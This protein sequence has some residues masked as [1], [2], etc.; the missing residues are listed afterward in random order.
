MSQGKRSLLPRKNFFV[1]WMLFTFVIALVSLQANAAAAVSPIQSA[2]EYDYPPFSIVTKDGQADGFSVELLREALRA[3]G[4]DVQFKV[5]PWHQLKQELADG[6]IQVLPLV[7]R[8]AERKLVYE[9]TA[10]YMSMHGTLIARKGDPR[11][12]GLD[13][14]RDKALVVLKGDNA[15]EYA[16]E[17][18]LTDKLVETETL[19]IGLRQLA[20]GQH[21]AML[22]QKLVGEN[23]IKT[24]GLSNLKTVGPPIEQFQDFCFAVRL[25]DKEL[26]A[27]LNEGLA[28]IIANDTV[29]RLREKWITPTR[30]EFYARLR[31]QLAIVLG[32]FLLAA[33]P[34]YL[35][36]RSKLAEVNRRAAQLIDSEAKYKRLVENSPDIVYAFSAKKGGIYYSPK[37]TEVLGYSIDHLYA[38]P[39]LWNESIHPDD[40]P[41][42][43]KA[44]TEF[45]KGCPF[46][47][48]Y[49]IKD[50]HGNWHWLHDRSIGYREENGDY[51]LEG[52]AMDVSERKKAEDEINILNINLEELVKQRTSE[53]LIANNSLTAARDA[54]ESAN[55]AKSAFLANMSHEIRT[56]M[57]GILGMANIL[58]REGVTP[59]QA[60]RLDKI[61]SAALH[62]LHIINDILD[63]SKI[64]AGKFIIEETAIS[65]S[66]I[67]TNVIS[68]LL[69]RAKDRGN[70]I[71]V[72]TRY[73]PSLLYGDPTRIQ[74]ALFNYVTNAI[75]FTENGTITLRTLMQD[76]TSDSVMVRFEVQD[77]GIGIQPDV[78]PRLFSAF[79]QADKSITRK[80]GGTGLGLAITRRL[81]ELMGGEAGVETEVGIGSTFWLTVRLRKEGT[82]SASHYEK[83]IDPEKIIRESYRGTRL[84]VVDDEP[85]N[86]E[87]AQIQ[88]EATGLTVDTAEDGEEAITMAQEFNYSAIL[89]D[90]Q[91]PNVDGLEATRQI[92]LLP[93]HRHTP[94]IAMTANA[95][96]EDKAL[97]FEA[98]M[99]DFLIKPFNPDTLFA[100]LLRSLEQHKDQ[101]H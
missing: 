42:V 100:T 11:I 92:R 20:D 39:F 98:G 89:M 45:E 91:M 21:D 61:D 26:L 5:G 71:L 60:E 88:L 8:N 13:D 50:A 79:E 35:V 83:S 33:I 16:R 52:M 38:N 23:L 3:V 57:N 28:L 9:F 51:I 76:E 65:I 101:L 64:E 68:M 46:E 32:V 49:R 1:A 62:L 85:I 7:G 44:V 54:A 86:R 15:G 69:E 17:H 73:L 29:E 4:R 22:V 37:V 95:F 72:E 80:Y 18:K 10:P 6:R 70:R 53:L 99:D 63:I 56:P 19:E 82:A 47:V 96:A 97:C 48:E 55:L 90:M 14:V 24:L 94:I 77:T 93:G 40:L 67:V 81:A 66:S 27:T 30:D 59:K 84:L 2:S 78:L 75:K 58:R 25:G 12:R 36:H 43:V 87:V 74:Q 31:Q 41:L 34:A